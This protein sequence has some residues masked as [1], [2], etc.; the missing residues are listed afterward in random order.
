MCGTPFERTR[1]P[2]RDWFHVMFLFST[3]RNGVAAKEVQRQLG[4]TY[5]TAWRMCHEIRKYMGDVDGN[6]P[7]GGPGK[8]VEIDETFFAPPRPLCLA[9]SSAA[10]TL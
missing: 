1:T 7:L 10:G 3:T 9:W 4:V 2:L 6:G 8:H 5:K